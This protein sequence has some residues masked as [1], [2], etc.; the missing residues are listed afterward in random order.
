MEDPAHKV[1]PG[2]QARVIGTHRFCPSCATDLTG[3]QPCEGDPYLGMTLDDR[4]VLRERIGEGAMGRVYRA[5]QLSLRKSFAVKILHAQLIHDPE[6]HARFANEAHNAASLNHPNVVSVVDY[7]RTTDGLSYLVME[8]IDGHSLEFAISRE[9]PL[10]RTR[11]VDLTLQILA[12]L[13]E[14]HGLSILHRDLKPENILLQQLRTHG[15]L[16]KVLDFGIAKLMDSGAAPERAQLTNQG[17]IFGTP[18]YMSPE[19]ARGAQLDARSDIYSVGVILYQMLTGRVPFRAKSPIEVLHQHIHE[20]P[21]APSELAG[22]PLGA[23]EQI[24]LRALS[25]DPRERFSSAAEFRETL[26]AA[27]RDLGEQVSHCHVC[28]APLGVDARFCPACGVPREIE[29]PSESA[30][31]PT[32]KLGDAAAGVS[33]RTAEVVVGSFPLPLTGRAGI[34]HRLRDR[35]ESPPRSLVGQLIRGDRGTGRTRVLEE[36]AEMG[37]SLGWRVLVAACEPQGSA[38]PL[39]PIRQLVAAVLD[40]DLVH[41]TTQDLGRASNL[42]DLSFEA[43]PGLAELFELQGPATHAEYAVRRRECFAAVVQ[44]LC[45]A[46]HGR[47][48][49]LVFDDIDRY[50]TASRQVLQQLLHTEVG[51]PVF[52]LASTTECDLDWLEAPVEELAPLYPG[53]VEAIARPIIDEFNPSSSLPERLSSSAP[54]SP[55]R[56][57]LELWLHALDLPSDGHAPDA[58]LVRRRFEVLDPAARSVLS[59]AAVLGERLLEADLELLVRSERTDIDIGAAL[60]ELH[61]L[62]LLLSAAPGERKFPNRLIRTVAYEDC[63]SQRRQ[64]LHRLAAAQGEAARLPSARA[65]HAIRGRAPDVVDALRLAAEQ[66]VRLFDDRKALGLYRTALRFL[67]GLD[68]ERRPVADAQLRAALAQLLGATHVDHDRVNA[69]KNL[70][71]ETHDNRTKAIARRSLGRALLRAGKHREAI[72]AFHS[73]LSPLISEGD[74]AAILAVYAE[75]GRGYGLAG[76]YDEGVRELVEG[77]DMCTMGEGPRA[78]TKLSLWRYM[79]RLCQLLRDAKRLREARTWCEHALYQAERLDDDLGRLR[80]HTEM[81]WVLRDLSQVTLAETH[82]ARALEHARYFGDRL[83]TAEILLERARL[84]A[85]RGKLTDA[86]RCFGEALRLAQVVEWRDGVGHARKA[87]AALEVRQTSKQATH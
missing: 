68:R 17:T 1:C 39:W 58:A 84:R 67:D 75:L 82:L 12:A 79:L 13:T 63:G 48:L 77:L 87:I 40:L 66:A 42:I 5:Q 2:C 85:S 69:A 28:N 61:G 83:T 49:L 22:Q 81:A 38:P 55:L 9:Y 73:A 8:L 16:L 41:L 62:G 80:C 32:L 70:A 50:D 44:A 46:G 36:A 18:E 60:D 29:G 74:Q 76:A 45:S 10:A 34:I 37:R 11:I 64:E 78:A 6:S 7:G 52:V 31:H 26:I 14:A 30:T 19:Q 54:L 4:Y 27:S 21:T 43:L 35:L 56:L 72:E 59:V 25:K 23:L 47:P 86:R 65:M 53:D 15:E 24:C 51:V 33:G 57:E 3:V 20:T 71:T